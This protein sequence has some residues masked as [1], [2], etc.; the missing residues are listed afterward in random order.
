MSFQ[1]L[2]QIKTVQHFPPLAATASAS[3]A[4][5]HNKQQQQGQQQQQQIQPQPQ[6]HHGH[7]IYRP[8]TKQSKINLTP[9]TSSNILPGNFVPIVFA[10][11]QANINENNSN[12]NNNNNNNIIASAS[13]AG[14]A[15]EQQQQQQLFYNKQ[16]LYHHHHHPQH[17]PTQQFGLDYA[18]R[19]LAIPAAVPQ[20][21]HHTSLEVPLSARHNIK[22]QAQS[23]IPPHY[24]AVTATPTT[25]SD[26]GSGT[27]SPLSSHRASNVRYV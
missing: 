10:P 23:P 11:V 16:P 4:S 19:P 14:L 25:P 2:L 6:P 15:E 13:L 20:Y 27:F 17:E 7:V 12:N 26:A 8:R 22:L 21:L 3:V 5:S 9:F 18:E 24:Y 1:F